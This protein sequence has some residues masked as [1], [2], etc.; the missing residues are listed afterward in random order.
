MFRYCWKLSSHFGSED[1]IRKHT[2]LLLLTCHHDLGPGALPESVSSTQR[3]FRSATSS[4]VPKKS[5]SKVSTMH[6]VCSSKVRGFFILDACCGVLL[7]HKT[8]NFQPS[9]KSEILVNH[10]R[11]SLCF[12]RFPNGTYSSRACPTNF[13]KTCYSETWD[14]SE[15][16]TYTNWGDFMETFSSFF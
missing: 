15:E 16:L 8:S 4:V 1:K 3:R 5:L 9:R 7:F 12:V 14:F 10:M 6:S 13:F 11:L 2:Q